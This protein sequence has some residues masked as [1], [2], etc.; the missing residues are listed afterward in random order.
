MAQAG[1][2]GP[3]RRDRMAD[4]PAGQPADDPAAPGARAGHVADALRE[5]ADAAAAHDED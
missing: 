4:R 3:D 1:T 2:A 5:L